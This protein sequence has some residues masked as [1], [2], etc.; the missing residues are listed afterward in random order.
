[1]AVIKYDRD[2]AKALINE[3]ADISADIDTN[4]NSVTS[5]V[6]GK[7]VRLSDKKIRDTGTRYWT[8]EEK[9]SDG[10]I[11]ERTKSETYIKYDYTS[12][13]QK[14]NAL[15]D[16]IISRASSSQS[17]SS[18]AI[19]EVIDALN[20]IDGLVGE[21]ES[22]ASLSMSKS[23]DSLG[24]F[25][26]N[27]LAAYGPMGGTGWYEHVLGAKVVDEAYT[28]EYLGPLGS[29]PTSLNLEKLPIF[30]KIVEIVKNNEESYEDKVKLVE[31][32]LMGNVL[33]VDSDELSKKA[34]SSLELMK[35]I[36]KNEELTIDE[37][38]K[39]NYLVDV[40]VQIVEDLPS[41]E[42]TTEITR[43]D[44]FSSIV[45]IGS[46]TAGVAS[47]VINGFDTD[48]LPDG[49][50]RNNIDA[51]QQM[52]ENL[53]NHGPNKGHGVGDDEDEHELEKNGKWL[54]SIR[55]KFFDG[56]VDSEMIQD[57]MDGVQ[58]IYEAGKK[59][60]KGVA[61]GLVKNAID[62]SNANSGD[63]S[64]FH[65]NAMDRVQGAHGRGD[66]G[67]QQITID[68]TVTETK[69]GSGGGKDWGSVKS[70][71]EVI[72]EKT[73]NLQGETK[74]VT[75]N[76]KG[77]Q[78]MPKPK[79]EPKIIT[80]TFTH[81]SEAFNSAAPKNQKVED[82]VKFS[83][84][85]IKLEKELNDSK[86]DVDY[87]KVEK[88]N[89]SYSTTI[90]SETVELTESSDAKGSAAIAGA[91]AAGAGAIGKLVSNSAGGSSPTINGMA[92]GEV[93][94]MNNQSGND[95]VAATI[96][97]DGAGST[98]STTGG[99]GASVSKLSTTTTGGEST[100]DRGS[101]S[102]SGSSTSSSGSGASSSGSSSGSTGSAGKGS[103]SKV[104]AGR[105]GSTLEDKDPNDN[106]NT[107]GKPNKPEDADDANKKGMLGDA[108]IAELNEKDEKQIRVAT[109]V[110][111]GGAL[112]TAVLA[113]AGVLP[114]FMFIL[115]LLAIIGLYTTYRIKKNSDKKK[116][117]AAYAARQA[118]QVAA[119]EAEPATIETVQNVNETS[120]DIVEET[121]V[122]TVDETDVTNEAASNIV[123]DNNEFSEQPYEP[124]RDG[125]TEIGASNN[126]N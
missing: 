85:D 36:L 67:H 59:I 69:T 106:D 12:F 60:G 114:S 94:G 96:M 66:S 21:F 62:M 38:L 49:P 25:D 8:V 102:S 105:G 74:D 71:D 55:D 78:Q 31:G 119:T 75:N 46:M 63:N 87:E 32:L 44:F 33:E 82:D 64:G 27:F 22:D 48:D 51:M 117:M 107:Y 83:E 61:D 103:T 92:A 37:N 73:N 24:Q 35:K 88:G 65:H 101:I 91:G 15:I 34:E 45:G 115:L 10:T 18:Q 110:S 99:S 42:L 125:V 4:L 58:D 43:D 95:I 90:K 121:V 79:D 11:I 116:R 20:K 120:A 19:Q 17:K 100:S 57:T 77:E 53:E 26:F 30:D 76:D 29:R 40:G 104:A 86:I 80:K 68:G 50:I 108:S 16:K 84:E 41:S 2:K 56:H 109:G 5:G 47:G 72:V 122:E 13:A 118:A 93:I 98:P 6:S 9:Q 124:S 7:K 14:F 52:I 28:S 112:G 126:N 3:L 23:L 54:E 97:G 113:I 39:V 1:M 111:A 89:G 123:S 70:A 81:K